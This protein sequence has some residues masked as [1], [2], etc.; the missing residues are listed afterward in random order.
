[1]PK[2]CEQPVEK[3]GKALWLT[4]KLYTTHSQAAAAF[5]FSGML[6]TKTRTGF[7]QFYS[8]FTQPKTHI[9]NLLHRFLCPVSTGPINNTNLIKD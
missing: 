7:A 5:R 9:F 4:E 1:M 2:V 6:C 8:A 3:L